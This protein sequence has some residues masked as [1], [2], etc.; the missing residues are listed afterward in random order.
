MRTTSILESSRD[1]RV[2]HRGLEIVSTF[3][4][5]SRVRD[6][7]VRLWDGRTWSP[8]PARPARFS[9]IFR[10]PG[11][12]RQLILHPSELSLGAAFVHADLDLEGDLEVGLELVF[13]LLSRKWRPR[14]RLR[15]AALAMLLPPAAHHRGDGNGNGES[16]PSWVGGKYR[17]RRGDRRAIAFHYDVS[18]EFY[19]LWLDPRMIYSCAY[20]HTADDDLETAQLQKLDHVC[21]KLRLRHGERLLDIGCGWGGLM[22]HAAQHYG[23]ES[24]GITLSRGQTE[25][26]Q[27]R[28]RQL[29]L[30]GAATLNTL[31]T[32]SW[33]IGV[34]STSW[35][36]LA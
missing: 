14:E 24:I 17:S 5:A 25:W 9:M 27:K 32:V 16:K 29:G 23:V 10:N 7:A 11:T 15:L 18:N 34:D 12:L 19:A 36:A 31:I 21:R 1:Q 28:I 4:G 35:P 33:P 6:F 20:F 26:A 3:F 22:I 2:A 30:E 13:D 8:D